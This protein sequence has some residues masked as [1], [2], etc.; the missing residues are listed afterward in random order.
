MKII[1]ILKSR[2]IALA[3]AQF[4]LAIGITV[5]TEYQSEGI[6]LILKSLLDILLRYDT[7]SSLKE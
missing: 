4:I 7:E 2:T 6:I 3:L 1:K 5:A